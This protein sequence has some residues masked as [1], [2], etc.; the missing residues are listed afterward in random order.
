MQYVA[1]SWVTLL[2]GLYLK[3][4]NPDSICIS[5]DV[6]K[7]VEHEKENKLNLLYTSLYTQSNNKIRVVYNNARSCKTRYQDVKTNYKILAADIIFIAETRLASNDMT[8]HYY[9]PN[10]IAHCLD[11]DCATKP[12]HGLIA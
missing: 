2:S 1:L 7:Y 4:L 9:I 5:T 3:D 11:Q 6:S 12:Y 10:F 8:S